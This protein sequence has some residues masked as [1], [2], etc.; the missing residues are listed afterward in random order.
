M[1]VVYGIMTDYEVGLHT[2]KTLIAQGL[3]GLFLYIACGRRKL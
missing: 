2:K 1:A 3:P